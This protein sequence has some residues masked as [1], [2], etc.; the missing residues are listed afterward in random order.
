MCQ[1]CPEYRCRIAFSNISSSP[2]TWSSGVMKVVHYHCARDIQ[3]CIDGEGGGSDGPSF[4]LI[5]GR[6]GLFD[7]RSYLGLRIGLKRC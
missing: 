6:L 3:H 5:R 1:I 4:M 2:L 7:S